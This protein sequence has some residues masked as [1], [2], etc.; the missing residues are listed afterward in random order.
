MIP[1]NANNPQNCDPISSNCVIWQGPDIECVN[2]CNG[3][4]VSTVVANL[5]SL[6]C[7]LQQSI[8]G[9]LDFDISLVDQTNLV[10][11]TATTLQELFQLLID[12]IILNQGS[13]NSPVGGETFTCD[14][15]FNCTIS[16]PPCFQELPG[17]QPSFPT[18]GTGT[19]QDV[20]TQLMINFC[21]N[22]SQSETN[23]RTIGQVSDRVTIIEQSPKGEPNPRI[24][25]SGVV[26]KGVLTPI[27]TVTQQL[28][29]QFI[30]LRNATG[31]AASITAA[32]ANQPNVTTPL[33]SAGYTRSL[34]STV[35]NLADSVYN[36]WTVIDDL[37]GA[38]KEIQDTC[39]NNA[40]LS[41]MGGIESLYTTTTACTTALARAAANTGCIQVWNSS[42]QQFDPTCRAYTS[43]YN[44][45][46]ATELINGN[47]YALCG[48]TITAQYSKV[49][50]Y[51]GTPQ[52]KAGDTCT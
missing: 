17:I 18:T 51:W 8:A 32:T 26:Q 7:T 36:C 3:D 40:Q 30:T 37:R 25:S 45:G 10:G 14:D 52:S 34:R 15:V 6:V 29:K 42:G 1:T 46:D 38:V 28:D 11:P 12:N 39:C 27:E 35:R 22:S 16:I 13:G 47:W 41:M 31:T 50:P 21:Q 4:T 33:D 24:Y 23:T 2:I 9:G 19:I 5:A 48:G 20:L 49:A 44:Q 43:P